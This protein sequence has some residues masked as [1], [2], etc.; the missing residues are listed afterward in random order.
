MEL[1]QIKSFVT[2]ART[3]NL[4]RAAEVL[5]TTPPS[6][7][8]HIRQ[9]EE[10]SGL[11][12][13]TR[14]PKGMVL[15]EAGGA[16]AEKAEAILDAA[17]SFTRTAVGLQGKLTGNLR[18]GLN[19]DPGFLRIEALV[20]LLFTRHPGLCLEAVP[21]STPQILKKLAS[22]EMDLGF[23]FGRRDHVPGLSMTFLSTVD[24]DVAVPKSFEAEFKTAGWKGIAALPWIWP[25]NPCPLLDRV[26][27]T[28]SEKNLRLTHPVTANDDITKAAMIRRGIAATVLERSEARALEREGKV[29]IWT[30]HDGLTTQLF[31]ACQTQREKQAEL[32]ALVQ[33][34][35]ELWQKDAGE[36]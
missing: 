16:L 14:T 10:Q 29:F 18:L 25:A 2:V 8:A 22:R 12:L 31:L 24:L 5:N 35:R 3:G 36:D 15:T 32:S 30:G 7:S 6:V 17:E 33:A 11:T 1:H 28:L 4:T 23:V 34:V 9:L 20:H 13:F 19:A 26:S 27:Q 21:S